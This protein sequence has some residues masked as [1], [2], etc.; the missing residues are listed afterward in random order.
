MKIID[1]K[2]KLFGKINLIDLIVILGIL[3]VAA[4][5]LLPVNFDDANEGN[6][7]TLDQKTIQYEFYV[8]RIREAS[9]NVARPGDIVKDT[10]TNTDIGVIVDSRA[11]PYL[12]EVYT[13]DGPIVNE[14]KL[15]Y[16]MIITLE[17]PATVNTNTILVGK[18]EMRI[19]KQ[20]TIQ[21]AHMMVIG[22]IWS[23]EVLD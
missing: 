2:G 8:Q 18:N 13:E 9:I 14:S 17:T 11:V 4:R 21:S 10:Q 20:M 16:D 12:E 6:G 5:F 1:E 3:L 23:I 19:G 7:V 15:Y 22:N